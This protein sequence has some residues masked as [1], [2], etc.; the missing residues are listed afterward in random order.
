[1]RTQVWLAA[2]GLALATG[3]AGIL[4]VAL[5]RLSMEGRP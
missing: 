4:V 5:F 3:L 1:M 2:L